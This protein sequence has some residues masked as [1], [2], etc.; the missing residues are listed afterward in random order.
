M[1]ARLDESFQHIRRFTADASHEMR[2]P[3]TVL[4]G[5]LEVMA[6]RQSL[7]DETRETLGSALE[8]TERLAQIVESLLTISRLDAG[9]AWME[10]SSFDLTALVTSTVE[11]MRLLAEDRNISLG[12]QSNG[13]V[14][15]EGDRARIKQ[16]VVNLLDNAIK[17]TP[18]G[19]AV[20]VSIGTDTDQAVM[21]VEDNGIGIPEEA[22]SHLFERFYR[23]DKARA[24]QMGGA[25]LGLAIVKSIITAHGGQVTVESVEGRGS[26]FQVQLPLTVQG[27]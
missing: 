8:E 11:Q 24:R 18:E 23:V 22:R 2:T 20:D 27:R 26:C 1:I 25:G 21:R 14:T 5:E 16:V 7:D 15:V 13:A 6:Q 9:E 12:C 19:G 10:R 17:Y 4:R 3:L